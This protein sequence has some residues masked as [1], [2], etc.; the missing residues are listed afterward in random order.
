MPRTK[1]YD[2][3]GDLAKLV[4]IVLVITHALAFLGGF[5]VCLLTV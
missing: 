4:L 3:L 2:P 1:N 5:L